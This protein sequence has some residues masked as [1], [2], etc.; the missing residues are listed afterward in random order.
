MTLP[1]ASLRAGAGPLA[2]YK[3]SGTVNGAGNF[4]FILTAKDSAIS[5]GPVIDIFRIKIWDKDA[6]NGIVYDNGTNQT[7]EGG[8]IVIHK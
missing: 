8:S 5:G 7:V 6:G 4:D 2:Q 3:G 1:L